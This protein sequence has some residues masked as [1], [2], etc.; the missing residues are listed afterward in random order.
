MFHDDE[1]KD[2]V[3]AQL[4]A[5]QA[6]SFVQ[7]RP[8]T[9]TFEMIDVTVVGQWLNIENNGMPKPCATQRL[10]FPE[11]L[12]DR[13]ELNTLLYV[14]TDVLFLRSVN[15]FGALAVTQ[16]NAS[17]ASILATEKWPKN[18]GF[19]DQHAKHPYVPPRGVNR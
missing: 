14:D 18:A 4:E 13:P 15:D 7:W 10:F 17:V 8:L 2:T 3:A 6:S 16:S 19:Y 5:W 11:L 9:L 1:N 12:R